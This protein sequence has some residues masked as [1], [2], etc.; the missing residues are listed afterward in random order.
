M[1]LRWLLHYRDCVMCTNALCAI[2]LTVS[3]E[4]L[5]LTRIESVKQVVSAALSEHLDDDG[6]H[7]R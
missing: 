5:W 7:L 6:L 3:I 2:V 4:Q 1:V